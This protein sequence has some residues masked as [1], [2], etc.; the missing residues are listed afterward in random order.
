MQNTKLTWCST[1]PVF[2]HL[3]MAKI[4]HVTRSA[5][6]VSSSTFSRNIKHRSEKLLKTFWRKEVLSFI[7]LFFAYATT[8]RTIED[9]SAAVYEKEQ[10]YTAFKSPEFRKYFFRGHL[11]LKFI[12][13]SRYYYGHPCVIVCKETVTGMII[14]RMRRQIAPMFVRGLLKC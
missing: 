1:V 8:F 14:W 11:V 6:Y 10:N 13:F 2:F 5:N 7:V 3:F 12:Q 9:S 4:G